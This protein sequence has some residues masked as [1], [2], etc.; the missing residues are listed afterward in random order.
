V[1]GKKGRYHLAHEAE[2][3]SDLVEKHVRTRLQKVWMPEHGL[4][5]AIIIRAIRDTPKKTID[6]WFESIV[7]RAICRVLWLDDVWLMDILKQ[8]GL[9]NKKRELIGF[10]GF[11]YA[12]TSISSSQE[13]GKR[14]YN[15][16][17]RQRV[18]PVD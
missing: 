17:A 8:S 14:V 2:L 5:L 10:K 12:K 6:T 3:A 15:R 1:R 18:V 7:C 13:Y 16:K 9:V 11:I 4:F